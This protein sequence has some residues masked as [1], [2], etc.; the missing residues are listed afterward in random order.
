MITLNLRLPEHVHAEITEDAKENNRSL[1][2]QIVTVI[3]EHL[4]VKKKR[5]QPVQAETQKIS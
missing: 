2:A 1:N 4:A 3:Q 5:K